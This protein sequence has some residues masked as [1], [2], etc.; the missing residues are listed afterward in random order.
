M[1]VKAGV[2]A[3]SRGGGELHARSQ[4]ERRHA[5][6]TTQTLTISLNDLNDNTPSIS[7]PACWSV[8]ENAATGTL[9]GV[10]AARDL[11]AT[12]P[13]STITY[14]ATGGTGFGLFDIDAATGVV[15]VKA[16]AA[17][18]RETAVNYTL[19]VKAADG[20]GLFTTQTLTSASTT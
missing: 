8:N 13:N 6:S 4:G 12:A 9:V 15:R 20:G 16:G 14:T 11:D 18:D 2:G 7:S 5:C 3:R 19:E 10:V 1:T 17:L